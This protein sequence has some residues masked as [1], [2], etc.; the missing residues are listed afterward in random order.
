VHFTEEIMGGVLNE[1]IYRQLKPDGLVVHLDE[2]KKPLCNRLCALIV[3]IV[4]PFQLRRSLFIPA[5][6]SLIA[7]VVRSE[8][9]SAFIAL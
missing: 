8:M 5:I 4:T 9:P 7:C 2:R 1:A 3:R 6:A